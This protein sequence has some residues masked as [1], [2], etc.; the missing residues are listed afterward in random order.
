[1]FNL[2]LLI[3]ILFSGRI[4][5]LDTLPPET[6]ITVPQKNHTWVPL[7]EVSNP[8]YSQSVIEKAKMDPSVLENAYKEIVGQPYLKSAN[9]TLKYPSLFKLRLESFLH[10]TPFT[11]L[12]IALYLLVLWKPF[13]FNPAF[14][15]HS[16]LLLARAYILAR[17]PVSNM[18]ETILY[19]PW[20]VALSGL[21]FGYK[22]PA[23]VVAALLLLFLPIKQQFENVQAV[24]DSSYWLTIHVLMVVGSYGL[25]FFAGIM[26]HIAL[27]RGGK[28]WARTLVNSMYVGTALLI[29]GTIL[30]GMWA[31]NSWGRFWDWDPKESWAFISSGLY[32]IIIHAYKFGVVK[33]RGLA[34]GSIIGLAAISFTWYG[35]NYILGT[36]LH[37]YGFGEGGSTFFYL[38][39]FLEVLFISIISFTKKER[40]CK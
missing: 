25:F 18:M 10:H 5:P 16:L 13:F 8:L 23:A 28:Q 40:D 38:Y 34:V 11:F 29:C 27:I 14:G 37:S 15:L 3:P 6:V 12:A 22:K 35:V 9:R 36:G 30:G 31:L 4:H 39:L 33:E 7:E 2:L 1:M 17:P 26:G 19:V 20:V 24:L 32:L 21:I